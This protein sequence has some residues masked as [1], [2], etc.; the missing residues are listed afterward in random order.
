MHIQFEESEERNIIISRCRHGVFAYNANG[1]IGSFL[2]I[3]GEWAE[4][5]VE[6]LSRLVHPGDVVVDVGAHI[7]TETVPL[8]KRVGSSGHVIAFEPQ[9]HLF[10]LLCTNVTLNGLG[11]V[12]PV[13]GGVG[14][15]DSWMEV[16]TQ[17]YGKPG[18]F[19]AVT[20]R[21]VPIDNLNKGF[22]VDSVNQV[23]CWRLDDFLAG[24]ERVQLIKIDVEG[25]ELEVLCGAQELI[26]RCRPIIYCEMNQKTT[27]DALIAHL[28]SL[29]YRLYWHGFQGFNVGNFKGNDENVTGTRGD[30]NV[31]CLPNE[32]SITVD[33]LHP[34]DNFDQVHELFPGLIAKG[35]LARE[36][37]S[38]F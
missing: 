2:F 9:K 21:P 27:G 11:N 29:D 4:P 10:H 17:H 18:N 3:Y 34:L 6:L 8:A 38:S 25:M 30:A 20:L 32:S 5:E 19:G 28:R 13:H 36:Y 31:L 12:T 22:S 37:S 26:T 14:E 33:G 23:Q 1:L 35:P 7:G 16:P 15:S 24:D